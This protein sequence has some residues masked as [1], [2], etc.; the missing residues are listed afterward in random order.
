MHMTANFDIEASTSANFSR[1]SIPL[2]VYR[3]LVEELQNTQ[4][5]LETLEA[6]KKLLVR[7]NQ[8]FQQEI[9]QL[10]GCVQQLQAV[11]ATRDAQTTGGR[12]QESTSP[13]VDGWVV[14]AT[15]YSLPVSGE[16]PPNKKL[17]IEI[18]SDR[19]ISQSK[20]DGKI[21]GW[22]LAIALMAIVITSCLGAFLIVSWQLKSK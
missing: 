5:R 19:P 1:P 13:S 21:N 18:E 15:R 16:N 8:Q 17:I 3:E 11:I 7:E 2:F 14:P 6:Q 4:A 22:V 20:G 12:E 10:M 9:E